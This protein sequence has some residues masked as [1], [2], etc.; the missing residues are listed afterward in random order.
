MKKTKGQGKGKSKGN[1]KGTAT[2]AAKKSAPTVKARPAKTKVPRDF[3]GVRKNIATLVREAANEIAGRLIEMA[4]GG[5][6]ASVKYLF[7]TVGLYPPTAE[8][9]SKPEDSLA[10]RLLTKLGL[11]TDPVIGKEDTSRIWFNGA[12]KGGVHDGDG[13][14]GIDYGGRGQRDQNLSEGKSG[15]DA[16]DVRTE[17]MP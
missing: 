11:P 12:V 3:A 14:D 5:H 7:E 15:V 2:R 8:I 6:L 13:V 4:K 17:G 1:N 10:Y 16:G 9:G